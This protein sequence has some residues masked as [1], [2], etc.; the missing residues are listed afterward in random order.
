M[1]YSRE[2]LKQIFHK[3][4]AGTPEANIVATD[5]IEKLINSQIATI[6][7]EYEACGLLASLLSDDAD[8]LKFQENIIC[9]SN[10][11]N[12]L[13]RQKYLHYVLNVECYKRAVDVWGEISQAEKAKDR[14]FLES[15]YQNWKTALGGNHQDELLQNLVKET[16]LQIKLV[17]KYCIQNSIYRFRKEYLVKSMVLHSKYIY[18]KVK[19]YFQNLGQD[20]IL[21]EI[22]GNKIYI[23]SYCYIHILFRHFS[24][25]L[26]EH[27][28]DKDYIYERDFHFNRI[29]EVISE[30]LIQYNTLVTNFDKLSIDLF[31]KNQYYILYLKLSKDNSG[32][33]LDNCYRVQTLFPVSRKKDLL[34]LSQLSPHKIN[35]NLSFLI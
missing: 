3:N 23:D 24:E 2:N 1:T 28:N 26:K 6:S 21:I 12:Y 11:K 29:P 15:E 32:R 19:E 33:V 5:L 16:R 17:Q 35:E 10:C 22:L 31:Y 34:R 14:I 13:F 27:Q 9:G 20:F 8:Y 18:L 4:S 30:M 7:E 25:S